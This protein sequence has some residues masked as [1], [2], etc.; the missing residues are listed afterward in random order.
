MKP[1]IAS[2]SDVK[3][4][5]RRFVPASASFLGLYLFVLNSDA[6]TYT[7]LHAFSGDDGA[8]PAGQLVISE[9]V[10]Y[11][12]TAQG[13]VSNLGT[14]FR[15]NLDGSDFTVLKEFTGGQD[16]MRPW[17]GCVLEGGKLYGVTTGRSYGTLPNRTGGILFAINTNG[18]GFTVLHNF[19]YGGNVY[20]PSYGLLLSGK[21][22]Y[23]TTRQPNRG[24][25]YK[26]NIDGGD[27]QILKTFASNTP[28]AR[29][30]L[31]DSMLYGAGSQC[32]FKLNTN[33]TGFVVLKT[34]EELGDCDTL[35]SPLV[36]SGSTLYGS[37]S[38]G[39]Y[40]CSC[41]KMDTN[42][43]GYKVL[44]RY[45]NDFGPWGSAGISGPILVGSRLYGAIGGNQGAPY[46]WD[47]N[48]NL[49]TYNFGSIFQLN[50][51]G[52]DFGLLKSFIGGGDGAY[53]SGL[54]TLQ[55][56]A[57]Y[58]AADYGG[59]FYDGVVFRL[60][61]PPE[62]PV[63]TN[64]CASR[65][66]EL[67]DTVPFYVQATGFL[68]LNFQWHS[69]VTSAIGDFRTNACLLLTNVQFSQSG[70]YQVVVTNI[71]GAITSPPVM[72]NVIAPVDRRWVPA[73]I[74]TGTSGI[75]LNLQ[76]TDSLQPI[77]QWLPF[78]SLIMSSDSQYQ[79]DLTTPLPP[80]RFYRAE[81]APVQTRMA[82]ARLEMQMVPAITLTG[83]VGDSW[84]L[85]YIP[86]WGPTDA[87]ETLDT[88][89]LTNSSQLYF[90]TSAPGQPRRLYRILPAQ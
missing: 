65:T 3:R 75:Q 5:W 47:T 15:M 34:A 1:S 17:G 80:Q 87:W 61:L 25:I 82:P 18:S 26:I 84:R 54:L 90:D 88:I 4:T 46:L 44:M 77:P 83:S 35:Y 13:G 64:L 68:P 43:G 48:V 79:F 76:Y 57:F 23:G 53:P 63:L 12:T 55:G 28:S 20:G 52:S 38:A 22:L 49:E 29:L 69:N 66:A 2:N 9:N 10:I 86:V 59:P 21:T 31:R 41:F 73:V 58:G 30:T 51:D 7:I 85:D 74:A 14:I 56:T 81:Q 24:T 11:G 42:G 40:Y 16:D 36:L 67:G 39:N 33:G 32:V 89:T 37:A 50:T 45:T 70:A 8:N 72:L 19:T 27:F 62:P 60:E 6:Q 71:F 78:G